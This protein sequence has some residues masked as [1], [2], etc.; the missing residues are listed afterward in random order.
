MRTKDLG[1]GEDGVHEG[2]VCVCLVP[3]MLPTEA[4]PV[5]ATIHPPVES[6]LGWSVGRIPRFGTTSASLP[7]RPAADGGTGH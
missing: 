5:H 1:E 3:T 7:E 6:I 2:V 4:P